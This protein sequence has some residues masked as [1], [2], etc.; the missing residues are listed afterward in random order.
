LNKI[1]WKWSKT[2]WSPLD[3]GFFLVIRMKH[4]QSAWM[5]RQDWSF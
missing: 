5:Q 2:S 1:K 4:S 3:N